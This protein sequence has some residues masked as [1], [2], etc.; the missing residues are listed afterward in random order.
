MVT[1][2]FARGRGTDAKMISACAAWLFG[3]GVKCPTEVV[4]VGTLKKFFT[5]DE[6]KRGREWRRRSFESARRHML[7][8]EFPVC[9]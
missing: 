4:W 2:T 9:G 1:K 7:E 6:A 3:Y 5:K 8:K